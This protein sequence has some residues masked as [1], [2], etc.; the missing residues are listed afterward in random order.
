M[1]DRDPELENLHGDAQR[2]FGER[3]YRRAHAACISLL[4]R[5]PAFA[6][7]WFLLGMIAAEHGNLGKGAELVERA[8]T[9]DPAR[10][11]Y[12]AQLGR[13]LVALNRPREALAAA[14]RGLAL[15]PRDAL[16]LDTLGV[17][18]SRTGAHD[19]AVAPF[20]QAVARDGTRPD[21]WYNL[22]ASLQFLGEFDAAAD[23]A[24][25]ALAL[26]AGHYRARSLLAQVVAP[27]EAEAAEIRRQLA[28]GAPS[29][30]AELHLCH[31]LA[32]HHEQRGEWLEAFDCLARGKARKC[33]GLGYDFAT[34]QAIF[35][36][37]FESAARLPASPGHPST[38]PIFIVGMPRTGTT[39]VERILAS[40]PAVFAA[41]E[42]THFGLELKRLAG[43]PSNLVLD[44]QTLQAA[45]QV[46]PATLGRRYLDSTRPRTGHTPH[47]IDKMPLN[48]FYAA[49]IARA[50][51]HAR[52]IC[53]RRDPMDTCLSNYRQL[54]ATGFSYY[55]YAFDLADTGRY[56]LQ[57]ERLVEHYATLL[58]PR[59]LQVRYED[60]VADTEAEARRLLG[61]CGLDWD[62][63]VLDFHRNASPVATASS[64]QVRQPVYRT[65][66]G[67]WR[68]YGDRLAPLAEVLGVAIGET[69]GTA[70]VQTGSK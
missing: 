67:R 25:R 2:A 68:R 33:A 59:L 5:Q 66:V 28:S 56:Y 27:G 41:G 63:A 50:L 6:D 20:R 62:P 18:L 46:D 64:V 65:S 37:A 17:V 36:A 22:A 15:A 1:G 34:D 60:V 47:F 69:A 58:G 13:C 52:L 39:L 54:F 70:S 4:E 57:F 23:A 19:E 24:R 8:I 29:V 51:P 48:F 30:D 9:L 26:D 3:D 11:E 7:A 14:R 10:A 38:E 35:A 43:T 45:A 55:R 21:Y 40:H 49:I 32:R 42:L 53:L 12:Q 44:P 16:T 61:F 31:A